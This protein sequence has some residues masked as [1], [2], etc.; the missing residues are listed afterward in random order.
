MSLIEQPQLTQEQLKEWDDVNKQL[1]ALKQREAL[2]RANVVRCLFPVLKEGTNN[3]SLGNGYVIKATHSTTRSI[4]PA[5]LTN[6]WN[7]MLEQ[8]IEV[9]SL[10]KNKPE[11]VKSEYNKL[12][13]QERHFFD[14]VLTIKPGSTSVE[15]VFSKAE[16]K[17]LGIPE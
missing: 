16:A 11:L 12:G 17:K 7:N 4:D 9:S 2:L 8:G 5:L 1:K 13:E 14:Q 15:I 6:L 3:H 10:V